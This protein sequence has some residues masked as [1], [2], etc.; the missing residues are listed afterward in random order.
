MLDQRTGAS[1]RED[2]ERGSLE[3]GFLVLALVQ[4]VAEGGEN[5]IE[6]S[7]L[8]CALFSPSALT[9]L[10]PKCRAVPGLFTHALHD[11]VKA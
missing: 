4:V 6:R 2:K 8:A 10:A 3:R 11:I 7:F 9:L 5:F 1:L